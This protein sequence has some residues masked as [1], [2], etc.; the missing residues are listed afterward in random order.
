MDKRALEQIFRERLLTLIQRF[1]G[2]HA[3]FARGIGID[4]SALSQLLSARIVRLPRAETLRA[5]AEIHQ[6]SLDWLL[7]LSQSETLAT[8]IENTTA[9]EGIA[10]EEND[11]RLARWHKEAAGY[12]I[13]YVPATIPDVLRTP[14][15]IAMYSGMRP[16]PSIAEQLK[17][18][19][20]RLNYNRMP[21]TDMEACMPFQR[22][23]ALAQGTGMWADLTE[24]DR[25]E[26]L[27]R[28]ET[29]AQELYPTFRLFL[30]DQRMAYSAPYTV[31]GPKRAAIYIGDMY[32]VINSTEHIRALTRHFDDLI[33]RAAINPHDI[34]TYVA[35]LRNAATKTTA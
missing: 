1:E 17:E 15:T 6:V 27:L 34:A 18:S 21:E 35:G 24:F 33:R 29:L 2:N 23:E 8:E 20:N 30:F 19:I 12:K 16:G 5:I 9:I 13:R 32:V 31:F 7:G 26:Q 4:R 14:A 22:L 11:S 3:E 28:I 10:D 25:E